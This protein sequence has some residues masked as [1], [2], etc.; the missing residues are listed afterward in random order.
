MPRTKTWRIVWWRPIIQWYSFTNF[1]QKNKQD[2]KEKSTYT[3]KINVI[4]TMRETKMVVTMTANMVM[5]PMI[6]NMVTT[7]NAM[8]A[9]AM[10]MTVDVT[11][12]Q[13]RRRSRKWKK[14]GL[15]FYLEFCIS[16]VFSVFITH[17]QFPS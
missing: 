3:Y 6:A 10:T 9:M 4:T 15:A 7:A 14:C 16:I 8:I 13:Q 2:W 1:Q 11:R 5:T 12:Q 17:V